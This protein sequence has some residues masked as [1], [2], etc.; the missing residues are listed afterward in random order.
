MYSSPLSQT[1]TLGG[2]GYSNQRPGRFTPR[3]RDPTP[4]VQEAGYTGPVRTGAEYLPPSGFDSRTVQPVTIR[5]TDN[6]IPAHT[7]LLCT[8]S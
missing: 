7:K 2:A 5:F 3:E 4:T 1:L 6:A 8:F